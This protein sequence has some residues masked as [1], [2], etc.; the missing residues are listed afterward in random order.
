MQLQL[1]YSKYNNI[2]KVYLFLEIK[3][4]FTPE[5]KTDK[6][7]LFGMDYTLSVLLDY[8]RDPNTRMVVIKGLRRVGKTSLLNVALQESHSFV[9]KIDVRDGPYAEKHEFL[10]FLFQKIQQAL[11]ESLLQKITRSLSALQLGYGTFSTTFYFSQQENLM[12]FFEHLNRYLKEKKKI[13]ILAFDEAQLLKRIGFDYLLASIFDNYTQIKIV[14]TGSEIGLLDQFVGKH[15]A[16]APLFNRI[17]GEIEVKRLPPEQTI[18]F[19]HE[20]FQQLHKALSIEE[21]REIIDTLD[22]IIGWTTSYGWFRSK[23][24]THTAALSRVKEE[25]KAL[26]QQEL[27]RFLET[28]KNQPNYLILL[29]ALSS[30]E[31]IWSDL[32]KIYAKKHHNINDSQL[33]LYLQELLQYGFIEKTNEKYLIADP[34]LVDAMK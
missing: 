22:G 8:I 24:Y 10:R 5:P 3:M 34:L 9:V 4:Y 6:K 32:K 21:S 16:H 7:D 30:G 28:R 13:L 15:D 18:R 25:G 29:R 33:Q 26:V 19:L 20:G 11:G 27:H 14:L 17:Y 31:R 2:Y 12:L 23:N 1:N